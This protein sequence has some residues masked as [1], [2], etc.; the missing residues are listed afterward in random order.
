MSTY[1][2]GDIQGCYQSFRKL[3]NKIKFNPNRDRLYLAGDLINRGPESL[4]TMDYVLRYQKAIHCVL[5]NHDLHFLAVAHHCQNPHPKDTF[6]DILES[7]RKDAIIQ[8]LSRQPLAIHL[9]KF[10]TLIVHA[11]I[12][13]GWSVEQA[14]DYAAEV[15][16]V[17]QSAARYQFYLAMYGNQPEAWQSHYQGTKRLRFITNVLTRM[18]YCHADGRVQLQAKGPLGQQPDGLVPWFE[19][20][21]KSLTH[22][23]VFGH[24]AALQ[25]KTTRPFA[26]AVDTGCVW[27]G[28]LTALRLEDNQ[29]VSIASIN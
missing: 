4:A 26:Q 29:R 24:W 8:W 18:R 3:L 22:Q 1:V 2:I 10:N 11:G 21:H 14:L 9:K 16:E 20:V 27:G 28:K 25:G 12:L 17:L 13:P 19:L 5:G 23:I 7:R 15:S 6:N